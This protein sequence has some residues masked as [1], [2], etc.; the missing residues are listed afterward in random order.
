MAEVEVSFSECFP[1]RRKGEVAA[2]ALGPARPV[3]GRQTSTLLWVGGLWPASRALIR[4][5]GFKRLSA[6]LPFLTQREEKK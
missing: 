4:R 3:W 5:P 2:S 6:Q 1:S